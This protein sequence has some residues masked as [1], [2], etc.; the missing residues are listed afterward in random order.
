LDDNE[1]FSSL[2]PEAVATIQ[3]GILAPQEASVKRGV[4]SALSYASLLLQ[5]GDIEG[6]K[7]A[8]EG[9]GADDYW[10]AHMQAMFSW[11]EGDL[12][13]A[14]DRLRA[15]ASKNPKDS[16][17]LHA[18][19]KLM[20]EQERFADAATL[21]RA[22]HEAEPDSSVLLNDLGAV[23]TA[24]GQHR[25]ALRV[26]RAALRLTPAY[27]L[28]LAN[29][30]VAHFQLRH[31]AK[32]VEY[33]RRA[34]ATDARCVAAVHNLAE[35]LIE[36]REWDAVSDLLCRHIDRIPQD[37]RAHELLAWSHMSSHRLRDAQQVLESGL[38]L[39]SHR[40]PGL[41]NNL[42]TV[43]A[44]L[45]DFSRAQAAF[46]A[47]IDL[48]PENSQIRANFA[49]LLATH[50]EWKAITQTL[51][52]KDLDGVSDRASLLAHALLATNNVKGAVDLLRSIRTRFS[53]LRFELMLGHALASRLG[54][55]KEAVE[56][57]TEA[58][59][60]HDDD[61][62]R[63]NLGYALILAERFEEA[64]QVLEPV[65]Q[66]QR[67]GSN[68]TALCAIASYGLLKIRQGNYEQGIALYRE[69]LGRA[70][71]VTRRRIKQKIQVEEGRRHL[72]LGNLRRALLV[73]KTASRGPDAEFCTQAELL[74][75]SAAN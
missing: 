24:A 45:R 20:S 27:A 46:R 33:F 69:A 8:L 49:H 58:L 1:L 16:R 36:R 7:R 61:L 15:L 9:G 55:V 68:V 62:L 18:L 50:N 6:A 72:E 11:R 57:Y 60:V 73:L 47:A 5:C 41:M 54:R 28:A 40:D 52:V 74:L 44:Q 37:A 32:A 13:G 43:Y 34:L 2:P 71:G 14:E 22:A 75:A 29:A 53:E 64:T 35:C 23:L 66:R 63:N 65:F 59:R 51:R 56:V 26:L 25:E 4:G 38:R 12:R 48:A 30:G 67:L 19:G 21:L 17:A 39:R 10:L 31:G 3:A 42:A 70:T